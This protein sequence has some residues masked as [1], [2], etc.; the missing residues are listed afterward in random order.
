VKKAGRRNFGSG[1]LKEALISWDRTGISAE[2]DV[3]AIFD[4]DDLTL[5]IGTVAAAEA[6]FASA[7]DVSSLETIPP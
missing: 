2:K 4:E 1:L 5:E 7:A 3:D 6:R